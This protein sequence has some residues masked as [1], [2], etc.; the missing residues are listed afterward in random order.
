MCMIRSAIRPGKPFLARRRHFACVPPSNEAVIFS[1]K[2]PISPAITPA[3]GVVS[4]IQGY[5]IFKVRNYSGPDCVYNRVEGGG[6][7]V[8]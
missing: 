2:P 7:Y 6:K 4:A 3:D 5:L 8:Q 1:P